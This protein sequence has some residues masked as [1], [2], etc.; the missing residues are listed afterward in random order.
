[1]DGYRRSRAFSM[2]HAVLTCLGV[3]D[4]CKLMDLWGDNKLMDVWEKVS[5]AKTLM[6]IHNMIQQPY[7]YLEFIELIAE[8]AN[9]QEKRRR[10]C[11]FHP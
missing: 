6:Q 3:L 4:D 11:F 1:M 7:S 9:M 8:K 10:T 2:V 5:D